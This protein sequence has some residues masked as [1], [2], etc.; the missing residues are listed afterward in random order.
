MADEAQLFKSRYSA[1]VCSISSKFRSL[2]HY[3]PQ[4][5][6]DWRVGR[7]KVAMRR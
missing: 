3:G 5:K 4:R 7:L 2:V 1:A 6:N